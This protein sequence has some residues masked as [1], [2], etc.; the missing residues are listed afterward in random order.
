MVE[1]EVDRLKGEL[2]EMQSVF[3]KTKNELDKCVKIAD[4]QE[5][6]IE[7]Y[8]S[9]NTILNG[10]NSELERTSTELTGKVF[11]SLY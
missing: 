9:E 2:S 11:Y 5:K 3:E 4:Q 7:S 8:K 6:A 10:R 1:L